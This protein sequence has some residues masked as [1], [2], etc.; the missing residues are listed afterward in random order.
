MNLC[1]AALFLALSM[2]PALGAETRASDASIRELL[3]VSQSKKL[4]D[5]AMGQ[6]DTMMQASMKQALAGKAIPPNQQKILDDMRPKMLALVTEELKWEIL[7]PMF[8]DIYRQS[9]SQTEI[10]GMLAF[11]KTPA[12]Q[13]VIAKMPLVMQGTMKS[14]Q[15]RIMAIMPRLQQLERET[16][17]QLRASSAK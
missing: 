14:V 16:I 11:Y 4:V 9:F 7:E 17:A 2:H 3:T 13:A 12:G 5:G 1:Y 15:A 6:M 8:I 10:D